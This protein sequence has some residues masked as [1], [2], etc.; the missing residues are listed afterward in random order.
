MTQKQLLFVEAEA[1]IQS[2][3]AYARFCVGK[4]GVD[5]PE[6]KAAAARA[7]RFIGIYRQVQAA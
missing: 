4:Y 5:A 7:L 2:A 3:A 6:T 1:R